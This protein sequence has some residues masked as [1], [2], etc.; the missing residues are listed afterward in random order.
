[1]TWTEL[2]TLLITCMDA[3]EAQQHAVIQRDAQGC[4]AATQTIQQHW[5]QIQHISLDAVPASQRAFLRERLQ[6]WHDQLR[7]LDDLLHCH[8][9]PTSSAQPDD[10]LTHAA[11]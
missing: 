5:H 3:T 4:W 6:Q 11:W 1:M 10:A 2:D 9:T 8:V 7:A